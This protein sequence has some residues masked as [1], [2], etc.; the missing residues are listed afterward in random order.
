MLSEL[1][2]FFDARGFLEVQPPCLSGCT[3]VDP[4]IDPLELPACQLQLGMELPEQFYLQTSPELAMKRMLAA[5]APSIYSLGPVFRAGELGDLHN[6]E[7]TMLEW[8][9]VGAKEPEGVSLLGQL[10]TQL[11]QADVYDLVSYRQLFLDSLGFDPIDA[12]LERVRAEVWKVDPALARSLDQDRDGLL[13]VLLSQCIQPQLGI[14]RPLIVRNYPLS[15]AAL[16]RV[17][18][19]DPMCASRFE[20][21]AAG[22]ELANGYDELT[23]PV[24]LTNR[25]RSSLTKRKVS[26]RKSIRVPDE[27]L[28]RAISCDLPRCTGVALGV[29]RLLMVRTGRRSLRDVLPFPIDSA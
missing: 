22:V 17:A 27:R 7:F 5:G 14:G 28:I 2:A 1:R 10:A 13:D 9:D 16:A 23:D 12:E 20:L 25:L 6:T 11:L 15:Q 8:Y 21:F 29:D 26:G 4:Y 3:L 24:I 18:E 19:D